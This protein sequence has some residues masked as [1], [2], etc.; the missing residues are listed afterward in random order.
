MGNDSFMKTIPLFKESACVCVYICL[1]TCMNP[2]HGKKHY[3]HVHVFLFLAL[4]MQKFPKNKI[5]SNI[6][7]FIHWKKQNLGTFSLLA[8]TP[9]RRI[10]LLILNYYSH[11]STTLNL[12]CN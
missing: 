12:L 1:P 8:R 6:F 5:I 10:N 7:L 2:N 4:K 11:C 9:H 3:I